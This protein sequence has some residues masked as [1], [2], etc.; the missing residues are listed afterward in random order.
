[1]CLSNGQALTKRKIFVDRLLETKQRTKAYPL[2]TNMKIN[3]SPADSCLKS[4]PVE[5]TA[6]SVAV[7]LVAL[8]LRSLRIN[9]I[10]AR[11]YLPKF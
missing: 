11:S 3:M 8:L 1:M 9:G 4:R 5:T 7:A 6:T 10:S 2:G